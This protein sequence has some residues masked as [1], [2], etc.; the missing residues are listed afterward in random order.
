VTVK[1]IRHSKDLLKVILVYANQVKFEV[2]S[3]SGKTW[4]E[5]GFYA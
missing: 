4:I 2:F 1:L 5:W 3:N